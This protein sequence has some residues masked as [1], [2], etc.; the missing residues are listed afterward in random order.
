MHTGTHDLRMLMS[1]GNVFCVT[2]ETLLSL[3]VLPQ[4][5]LNGTDVGNVV[6]HLDKAEGISSQLWI[7]LIK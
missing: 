7:V 3:Q 6:Q 5:I 4:G 1:G 2:R